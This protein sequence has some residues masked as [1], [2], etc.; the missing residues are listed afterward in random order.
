MFV[1]L[2]LL[3]ILQELIFCKISQNLLNSR[4]LY[5]AKVTIFKECCK[6]NCLFYQKGLGYFWSW[7]LD[8]KKV[9]SVLMPFSLLN[10]FLAKCS[11]FIPLETPENHRFSGIFRGY[12]KAILAENELIQ[13]FLGMY[14]WSYF[15]IF[16]N[17]CC[18]QVISEAE[19]TT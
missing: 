16:Q 7:N 11:H 1:N 17:Y 14:P 8:L 18:I 4:K 13:V 19:K 5:P 10:T 2:S 3:K 9:T 12:K 15:Q 6:E